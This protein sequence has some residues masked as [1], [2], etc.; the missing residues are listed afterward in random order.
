MS[1]HLLSK[2][3]LKNLIPDKGL[4]KVNEPK[5]TFSKLS[6]SPP[7]IEHARI[8][9]NKGRVTPEVNKRKAQSPPP[10]GVLANRGN[11]S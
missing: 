9:T 6:V 11:F 4:V 5:K 8:V 10:Q 2:M 7:K 3:K 1:K